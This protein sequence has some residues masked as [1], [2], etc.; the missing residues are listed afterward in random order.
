MNK[1]SFLLLLVVLP[2]ISTAQVTGKIIDQ[3]NDYPLEYATAA[4]FNQESKELVTGVI[5]D[6]D[7]VF[8]IEN[9][10]NGTYYLEASFIG[11]ETKTIANIKVQNRKPVDVGSIP[12]KIGGTVLE[13]VVI[14]GERATVIN[15]ID[16]QVF[17]ANKFQNSLGG[18]ATDII[19]NIPSVTV[20]AQGEIS[21]RGS[22]GFVVLLN[23]NPVQGNASDL[24]NQ[25]PANAVE[26]VE[27]ITAPSA[28]YDPE[29]KAGLINIIT[30]K[31]ATDGSFAQINVKGGFPSIETY[32]NDEYHQRYGADATY[33]IRKEDW[34]ISLGASFQR[35]DLGG[36]REGDVF[37]IINDT[38][39]QFPSTGERSF[40][41]TNYSGRFTVDYT[42]DNLNTFS[43]GFYAGK[44]QKDRLADIVYYD[45]HAIT[46]A[47]G[48][49]RLYTFQYYNHNLRTRKS[50]FA[51]GSFDY[52][53]TFKNNS[54]LSTSILYE[55][56]LLGGPTESDNLGEPNRNIVYQQEYNTNDNPLNGFRFQI[57]YAAK[58]FKFA[59]LETGYQYRNLDHTGDFVYERKDESTGN[60]FELVPEFSS[61]V[62]LQRSIHSGYVQ[63]NGARDKWEYA[64]GLRIEAM[65]RELELRD[66]VGIIDTTYTYD[67]VKPFPTASVQ[68][69]MS[70]RTKVKAA[71]SKR[72]ERT[73][74]FKMNPFPEREHSE[75]LEQGDPTL[76]PEFIDLVELGIT[77]S[78]EGG[79]SLFATAY[80]RSTQNLVNRVN[81]IYNDTILNRIYSNVGK[82]K[83]IGLEIGSQLKPLKNWNNFI[84][85]NLYNYAI[86]G[87]YDGRPVDTDTFVYSINLNS[88]YSLSETTSLQ[89]TFNYL[90]EMVT[91]QGEDSRFYSPNLTFK[92]S[93][94]DKRLTATLQWQNIDAGLLGSNEQRIMTYRDNEFFTTTNYVYEVDMVLLNLSYN[95]NNNKNKSK[96]IDSEFGKKEF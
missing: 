29:G 15:K 65:D 11:F 73:T 18:N 76:K 86:D 67:Y 8:T 68:Y 94:L 84:G 74:T 4:L 39:T 47:S 53:H 88:T 31:G 92:K 24:L 42:P 37:T 21:V 55:Y 28:K 7:G 58:P 79:N 64:A 35:N 25:F 2:F 54:R 83:A 19:K 90:S 56:T 96:F 41:E 62:D 49:D 36:R 6:M 44:R 17:D 46:P 16:R 81:T 80:Y 22:S 71:Y 52:A 9:V 63:L 12:L 20:D 13:E 85:V 82:S 23:G 45:N 40:D 14:Q 51:L 70:D 66:K 10:K 32:G 33:N 34:N 26:R 27:V 78:F 89:F 50:D 60:V 61:E 72:V 3:E 48:G 87:A 69:S 77:Q 95:F 38:L 93:F 5:T 1:Y 59:Q 57:D 91:A 75:T 30:K 43:L